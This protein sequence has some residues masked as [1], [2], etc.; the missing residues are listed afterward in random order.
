MAGVMMRIS[1]VIAL[2][3]LA[4]LTLASGA[5]GALALL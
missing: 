5:W 1:A 2:M 4:L 3:L